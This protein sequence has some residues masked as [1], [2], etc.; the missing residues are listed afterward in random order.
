MKNNIKYSREVKYDYNKS[1]IEFCN[2]EVTSDL[3]KNKL[4]DE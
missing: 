1:P 2:M 3:R 4:H